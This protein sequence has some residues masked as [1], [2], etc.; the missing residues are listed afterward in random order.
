MSQQY[1]TKVYVTDNSF[2][3]SPIFSARIAFANWEGGD[4]TGTIIVLKLNETETEYFASKRSCNGASSILYFPTLTWVSL[5]LL[6]FHYDKSWYWY[7]MN[8][9]CAT[10]L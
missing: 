4:G 7:E 10:Q 1:H 5:E 6:E 2:Q 8:Q 9:Q 3:E